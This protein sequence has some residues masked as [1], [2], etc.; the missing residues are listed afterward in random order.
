MAWF[1]YIIQVNGARR[2]GRLSVDSEAQ[3]V[4]KLREGGALILSLRPGAGSTPVFEKLRELA[5]GNAGSLFVR[6]ESIELFFRQ[7][8]TLLRAGVPILSALHS[9]SETGPKALRKPLRRMADSVRSGRSFSRAVADHLPRA[10]KT[11]QGLMEVGESNGSLDRMAAH[12]ADLMERSRRIRTDI[13]QAMGY[14]LLV[15]VAGMGM[16]YY[17]VN[18]I[19]PVLM[20]FI[21][22]GRAVEQPLPTRMLIWL[23]D[24]LMAY[25]VYVLAAPIVLTIAVIL[26][27]RNPATGTTVDAL[28]LRIPLLGGAIRF[29]ANTMWCLVLGS[30]LSSGLDVLSAV[31]LVE[32][33]MDNRF[34]QLQFRKVREML[35]NGTGFS[36]C[37]GRTRL[38]KLCPMSHTLAAVNEESGLLDEGLLHM[39]AFSEDRLKRRVALLC[40]MVEPTIFVFVGGFVGLIYFGFFLAVY[41][42]A[43]SAR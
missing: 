3:A 43:G 37:I 42:A 31:Q 11:I 10:D 18:R 27:R 16:G 25:G 41:A 24:F 19:F 9:L 2:T 36:E 32:H 35:R 29:Y 1:E 30:M 12:A 23:N 20:Q 21:R 28:A 26:L 34:Y 13:R 6:R 40:K 33:T 4:A 14:P 39:A 17:M 38:H 8:S 22:Q 7:L 5:T 15:L